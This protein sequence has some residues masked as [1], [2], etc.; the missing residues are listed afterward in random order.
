MNR[1]YF[2]LCLWPI[3]LAA[4]S[5]T[6]RATVEH[7]S[8]FDSRVAGY[9]GSEQAAEFIE[10]GFRALGLSAR[11][12]TFSVVVP[13]DRGGR[14]EWE[15][16]SAP[17][18]AVW[19][20]GARTSTLPPEG[21]QAP[22]IWGGR[23][24]WAD[25]N[26]REVVGRVVVLD[27]DSEQ[28][29]LKAAEL[30]ARAV[31]FVAPEASTAR[32]ALTKYVDVPLDVPR[33]WLER[34]AGLRLQRRLAQG[35][36]EVELSGRM[37]WTARPTWNIWSR[38][39]G[40]D[41]ELQ[42]ETVVVH[43]YYDAPSVA[44]ALAPGAEAAVSAAVLL[45]IARTLQEHP[46][47]RTVILAALSAHFQ[48]SQGIVEFLD[49][50]ARKHPYYARKVQDPLSPDLFIGLDLSSHG[51][52]VVLWNNT[53]SYKLKRFFVPF[54][55]RFSAYAEALG[56]GEE[57]ANGISPI[58]G[59]DWASFMPGGLAADG[60]M[61]LE[62]GYPSL[63]LAT[64]NDA[65]F[66]LDLPLDRSADVDFDNLVSQGSLVADVLSSA[67]DD[68]ALLDGA[69]E[70]NKALK[71]R[72]RDLRVKA[73]TFPRRSQVPDRPVVGALV[74]VQLR[75][76]QGIKGVRSTRYAFSNAR[77]EVEIPGL[78]IG[79]YPLEIYAIDEETGAI[80]HVVDLST[81]AQKHHGNPGPD[82]RLR[83]WVRWRTNE[84]TAVLFPAVGRPFYGFVDPRFLAA[85]FE[86][87]VLSG[88]GTEPRQYGYAVRS[89][90]IG[91]VGML[92]G[93]PDAEEESRLKVLAKGAYDQQLL[94]L[95]SQGIADEVAARGRGFSLAEEELGAATLQAAKDMWALDEARMRTLARHGIEN[96][97]LIR[98]HEK[99][100]ELI[101]R[102]EQAAKDLQ[103]DRY[104]AWSREALGVEARAY[105]EVLETLNDVIKG[106]VF[107]LALL[108]P[109]AFFG[110]RLLFA[111]ADIRRQLAGFGGLLVLIWLL[112]SQVHPAFDLAHPLVIL[113]A[114]AI[115]AMGGL[116][117]FMV[118]G[119]FN[120]VMD[121]HKSGQMRVHAQDL[122]RLG[123]S[124][125]AF[126]LGI[127]NMR[128][129]PLRTALTLATLTL[130][131]FTL[132]SFTSFEQQ[133]R[134]ASFSLEH[135]GAYS[136]VMIRD[137]GW[138]ELEIQALDYAQS[139]F[140]SSGQ[141]VRRNWYLA[142]EAGE[143]NWVSVQAEGGTW[144]QLRCGR[145][146]YWG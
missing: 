115:L 105:P 65:R 9:P 120:R 51:D 134:Y 127:S 88:S 114:F 95:N 19:P 35:E 15:G 48:G 60:I 6:I 44:P 104:V 33:F 130:L 82:G 66:G 100:R 16:E 141:V 98:L 93:T 145:W 12:D 78:I 132:L 117:L 80:T 116:V 50:H 11:R 90:D 67:L 64:V 139:H 81:R 146:D 86:L 10:D 57:L 73:R 76:V 68:P 87:K 45:E 54:G 32:Q 71:D 13:V 118:V 14:I 126:M 97:R 69:A 37:D 7:L 121:Q 125:A 144:S 20:N 43:A 122:S 5:P 40:V 131:T 123:A 24:D 138:E 107:F 42:D 142:G 89:S 8:S 111:A 25:F 74:G 22:A 58:R 3:A 56:R 30:G 109:A 96:Q 34:T 101:G 47:A 84:Q 63:T 55:R 21:L 17:L 135:E 59:M 129:R 140:G 52:R 79:G 92:Y 61:A 27:F 2:L 53:S 75:H 113:L 103:W 4:E 99:A 112:L 41:P 110:E 137:R 83:N 102:A 28:N 77:G 38:I 124:Y 91:A 108:L 72:L 18:H 46:P 85:D 133:I 36:V 106:M 119:R 1:L 62:A 49:R 94:L 26:G 39:P 70:I 128:R 29:W 143:S 31:V 23:G 136:G